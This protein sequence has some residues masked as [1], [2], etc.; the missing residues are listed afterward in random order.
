MG[1]GQVEY[2]QPN[3]PTWKLMGMGNNQVI[4][5]KV[6]LEQVGRKYI[7]KFEYLTQLGQLEG[8]WWMDDEAY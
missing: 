4:R 8:G 5:V 1:V 3:D 7:L 2:C 6:H